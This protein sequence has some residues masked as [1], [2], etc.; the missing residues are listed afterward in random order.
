[1]IDIILHGFIL[2]I[3]LS[4][5]IGPAFFTLIQT[6]IHRGFRS[7][8]L[9]AFG[10]FLSD[11]TLIILLCFGA[12]Q[13]LD[14]QTNQFAFGFAGGII[15]AIFGVVTFTRKVHPDENSEEL[16]LKTPS[17]ITFILKGFFLNIANPFI[18]VFWMGVM[19]F[20]TNNYE[21]ELRNI[22]P[23][24]SGTLATVFLTDLLKSFIA[25]KIKQFFTPLVMLIINRVVGI[26]LVIFGIILIYKVLR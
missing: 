26:V 16:Y 11:A 6:S 13:I 23:F 19:G 21:F 1:M 9:L 3:T 22:V 5:F 14:N 24:Y 25:N 18:W 10:I 12:S 20:V 7:A 2:G 17:P 4:V 15:L 8:F